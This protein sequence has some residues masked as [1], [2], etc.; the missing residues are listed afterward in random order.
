MAS[1]TVYKHLIPRLKHEHASGVNSFV[2][3]L[4]MLHVNLCLE[5]P[6]KRKS[7]DSL[8]DYETW[9]MIITQEE[10]FLLL[11]VSWAFWKSLNKKE[12]QANTKEFV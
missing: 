6:R 10:S 1:E 2:V 7:R 8:V 11:L 4:H 5:K 9:L 3:T 12:N